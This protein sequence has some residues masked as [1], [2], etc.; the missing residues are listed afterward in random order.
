MSASL[1]QSVPAADEVADPQTQD[2]RRLWFVLAF[3]AVLAALVALVPVVG[4]AAIGPFLL[5]LVPLVLWAAFRD[6]ERAIYIYFAWCWL[7]GTIRGLLHSDPVSIVARDIVLGVIVVGW[8]AQRLNTR[9]SDPIR[10]PP[11]TLLVAL[12][13]IN[14]LLQVFNPF[15]VGIVQS[16][17]GLKLH[18]SAIPLLFLGYDVIRRPSQVR[19]FFLFLTLLTLIMGCVSYAQYAHGPS[20]T[21]AHFPGTQ[22]A[23]GSNLNA[24]R[25]GEVRGMTAT[26]KPPGTSTGG[27]AAGAFVGIIFPLAF[28]LPLLSGSLR[29]SRKFRAALIAVLLA[30]IVFI[31]INAVRSAL[32]NALCGILL[33]GLLIGGKLRV[34]M[35]AAIAVCLVLG[36]IAFSVSQGVSQGGVTDRFAST[37]A[38]PVDAL[39]KD[40]RTF[41]DDAV[42]IVTHSPTGVGLGRVGAAGGR[43]GGGSGSDPGFAVF[44]EAYLGSI[45]YETGIIGGLLITALALSFIWRCYTALGRLTDPDDKLLL[46]A[47]TA[48]LVIIFAN[49]FVTPILLGP[50]GSVLFWLLGGAAL[51]VF[52]PKA[53]TA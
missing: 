30:L 1:I 34:R 13:T 44:S 12:F 38:D 2:Q 40:R 28:V 20:W 46:T 3:P 29:F 26:F 19:S 17:G 14:C 6:T 11:G 4:T 5:V 36:G 22:E 48:L 18:L 43:L 23:I 24:G 16:I 32:V 8:G 49:F 39:H 15:A 31:F 27:G 37:F 51:R 42:F 53:R 52:A 47:I 35:L 41:F 25:L 7:D 50:P 9:H 21:W 45:M 33:S 10:V